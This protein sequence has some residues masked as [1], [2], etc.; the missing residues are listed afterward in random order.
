MLLN[1]SRIAFTISSGPPIKPNGIGEPFREGCMA[2][3]PDAI[4]PSANEHPN[5]TASGLHVVP[6]CQSVT[7]T[8]RG[9]MSDDGI[10][11]APDV[12]IVR[13]V[14]ASFGHPGKINYFFR[15]PALML[16][17]TRMSARWPKVASFS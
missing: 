5:R 8:G 7:G 2:R 14:Q 13:G 6:N 1:G 12:S 4:V 11:G 16:M 15:S 10:A 3:D 17:H 9:A